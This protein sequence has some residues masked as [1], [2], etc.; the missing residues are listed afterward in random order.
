[1]ETR[2]VPATGISESLRFLER[3]LRDGEPLPEPFTLR[4]RELAERDELEILEARLYGQPAGVA[5]LVYRPSVSV[6]NLFA[7]IEE[8]HVLPETQCQGVGRALI[9]TVEERCRDRGVSYL[10]VQTVEEAEPFYEA[11]GYGRE[12]GVRVFSKNINL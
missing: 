6:G 8:L 10:E 4:L 7:S 2:I 11:L 12:S 5:V 9:E 3:A 1:M